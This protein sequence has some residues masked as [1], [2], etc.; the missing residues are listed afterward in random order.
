[1][2]EIWKDIKDYEGRYQVSNLGNVK[3][4]SRRVDYKRVIATRKEVIIKKKKDSDGYFVV[5]LQKDGKRKSFRVCRLVAMAFVENPNNLP[6]VNHKDE[7]KSNDTPENLE[8]CSVLY[9]NTYGNRILNVKR[10]LYKKVFCLYN[11]KTYNSETE[12]AKDLNVSLQTISNALRGVT[13]N[14]KGLRYV[15]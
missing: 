7:T 4:L 11:G 5:T 10:K 9:N 3:S 14:K 8:W 15:E 13:K 12:A 1:M 2:N 6:C